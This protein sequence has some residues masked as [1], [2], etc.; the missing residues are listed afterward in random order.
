MHYFQTVEWTK[1]VA[2]KSITAKNDALNLFSDVKNLQVP[3]ISVP[4]LQR[5]SDGLRVQA[6][7]LGNDSE[8]LY[9]NSE[10]LRV[11]VEEKNVEARDLLDEAYYQQDRTDELLTDIYGAKEIA[12]KSVN[13][14]N[15]I[16]NETESIYKDLKGKQ[17]FYC[18]VLTVY[19]K[20][21]PVPKLSFRFRH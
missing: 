18:I 3:E 15:A 20:S 12:D 16:L 2:N 8:N 10:K 1:E 11:V 14:W 13:R 9:L 5:K 17:M 19:M 7:Q 4:V 21:E 6:Y